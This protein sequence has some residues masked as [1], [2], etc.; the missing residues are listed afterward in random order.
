M[1]RS[2][3]KV[4]SILVCV[5]AIPTLA[6]AQSSF[7][8]AVTDNTGGVMPGVTVEVASP[9]LIEKVRTA[10]TDGQ[11]R[12]SISELRPGTYTITFSLVGF[13]TV[14]REGVELPGNFTATVNVQLSVGSLEETITV[15]GQAPL[16]DVTQAARTVVIDRELLDSLPTPRNTQSFGYLAPGVRLSKPDV[17]G[18]QQMEQVNMRV[19]GASQ[20]HT[21]MQVDGMLVSPSFSDGAIQNY[22]N[23][24]HFGETSFTTSSLGAE[25]SAGGVRLNMIP[26]DG[27]NIFSGSLYAGATEAPMQS[28]NLTDELKAQ[29]VTL[30]TGI[31]H[32]RDI[33]P[34]YGG[35]VK[36]DKLWFFMS[37][38]YVSVNEHAVNSYMP[39]GSVAV[40]DQYV[41]MALGRLTAQL[42]DKIKI[43]GFVD[44]VFKFK[45]R[46]FGQTTEPSRASTRRN[47]GGG[48]YHT[49]GS[50]FTS[51]VSNRILFEAGYTQIIE[52]L[53]H[54]YQPHLF[55]PP[56]QMGAPRPAV[57]QLYTT[58]TDP[59][60][61][62]I[63]HT[64]L[65]PARGMPANTV[66]SGGPTRTLP[67][68]FVL[69]SALSYVTGTHN[70][71]GG[72]QWAW[73]QDRNNAL[74]NGDISQ[75]NYRRGV[76]ESVVVTNNPLFTEEYVK[77]DMGFY[78]QDTWTFKRLTISPGI[79]YEDFN[80]GIQEQW[81]PPGR[82]VPGRWFAEID[83][84]PRW[85]DVTPRFGLVYDVRGDGTTAIK[86]GANKYVRP[87]AGSFAKNYNPMRGGGSDTRDWFDVDLIPGTST[88]SGI[89][90]PTDRDDVV[91]ENEVGPSNST[92]FGR[93]ADRQ[94]IDGIS[95][96]LNY[97]YTV[98]LQHQLFSGLSVTAGWYRRNYD[99]LIGSDNTLLDPATDFTPFTVANPIDGTPLTIYNLNLNKRGQVKTLDYNSDINTHISND[100]EFSFNGRL[101]NGSTVF[102]NWS[103]SRNVAVTCDNDN[104]NGWDQ[105]DLYYAITFLRGGR[106][107]DQRKLSI[108]YRQDFKVA[109]TLPL[110]YGFDL[111]GTIVSFAG[112]ELQATWNVPASVFPNGQRTQTTNVQLIQPGTKFLERWNQVD[113]AVKKSFRVGRITYSTQMD[114]YNMLNSSVV[115]TRNTSYGPSLDFPQTI[116]QARLMRLVAQIKW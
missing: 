38:R 103:A 113:F 61:T 72:W 75:M 17:G 73:G 115:L 32:I 81:S 77:A 1:M 49:A 56:S 36:R 18:A 39:D 7:V 98:S 84:L 71:K 20:L 80:A 45:G 19:H 58:T 85:R 110:P 6:S 13:G 9:V 94:P 29:G 12:Y 21:T 116:I 30:P 86:F 62:I 95:R 3:W 47:W 83:N 44:R 87:M 28:D 76:P 46:E 52:R 111:S 106:F 11:G 33:N 66:A 23:Q 109:G 91:Q 97:E 16:V 41:S 67:D 90:K 34:S 4:F 22:M 57:L 102:G 37:A 40:V 93:A 10:I 63:Q 59:F 108:P 14:R 2:Y 104:P 25:V 24:A 64:D 78:I 101:P 114:L 105:S 68:R 69:M 35:P 15:S 43:S 79:R 60:F 8:G 82:W 99:K 107:C 55:S 48:N 31:D 89:A 96:E 26:R 27:G 112:N 5:L 42:T 54:G 88:R 74:N 100:F 92:S 65:E 70:I 53:R 51:T 50:K